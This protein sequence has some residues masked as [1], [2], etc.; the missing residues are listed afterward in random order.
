MG[1]ED[2][3]QKFLPQYCGDAYEPCSFAINEPHFGF[4]VMDLK[5]TAT[6]K[7][8]SYILDGVK[9]FVP[10]AEASDHLLVA[11]SLEGKNQLFIVDRQNPGLTIGGREKNIGLYA[12]KTYEITLNQCE[13][14]AQYRLGGEQGCD[15]DKLIQKTR[16]AMAAIGTG[17]SRAAYEFARDYA[18]DRVQFGEPITHRQT[19]AFM[20]AE[21]AYEVEAMRLMTWKAADRLESG[22]DAKREAYLAKIFAGD[23]TMKITDYAVQILGGHGYVREYPVERYYRNGRCIAN[24]EGMAVV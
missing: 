12:L 9:C 15:Y 2:Q 14:P 17:V 3:K 13:V 19:I 6:K 7:N 21:M 22:K 4:D 18:K 11:A 1:T 16:T 10:E 24:M 8:A 5:T 23:M 20:I